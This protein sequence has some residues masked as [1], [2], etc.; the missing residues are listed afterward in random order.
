MITIVTFPFTT[1]V[2]RVTTM[3]LRMYVLASVPAYECGEERTLA[4][5]ACMNT[6]PYDT[7]KVACS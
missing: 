5:H 3:M 1:A 7:H 4:A 2:M 6:E